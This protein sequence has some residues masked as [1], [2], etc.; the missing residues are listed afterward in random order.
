MKDTID[1]LEILESQHTEVNQLIKDLER[2]RGDRAA[3]FAELADK[4]A[5]H[6]AVEE[7]IFY[8]AAMA[9]ST[10]E[11]LHEFVED[12]LTVKRVLADLMEMDPDDEDGDFDQTLALLKDEFRRHS[13]DEEEDKLFPRVARMM[14]EEERAGLGNEVLAMFEWLIDQEPRRDVPR[15]TSAPAPLPAP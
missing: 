9:V 8:P 14:T 10:E 11:L 15:E 7:K 5:A 2:G 4:V 6:S 12:H 1:V 13:F 3:L